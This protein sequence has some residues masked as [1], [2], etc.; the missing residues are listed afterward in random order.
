ML[1]DPQSKLVCLAVVR[2][3]APTIWDSLVNKWACFDIDPGR[4]TLRMRASMNRSHRRM[5]SGREVS[6]IPSYSLI[7]KLFP[8]Q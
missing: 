8:A 2:V 6:S 1:H 5:S 3:L 7:H 4:R